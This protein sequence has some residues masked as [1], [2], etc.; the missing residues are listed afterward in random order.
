ML[1]ERSFCPSV[2]QKSTFES[3]ILYGF[4]RCQVS[5]CVPAYSGA[6]GNVVT[7]VREAVTKR[8]S[9]DFGQQSSYSLLSVHARFSSTAEG[10]CPLA[11]VLGYST[12]RSG[13]R[14]PLQRCKRR[15][16]VPR[17]PFPGHPGVTEGGNVP[18]ATSFSANALTTTND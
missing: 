14:P 13:R 17:L 9:I 10:T 8:S 7:P 11:P 18:Q 2:P 3:R 15:H 6:G 4:C 16:R 12:S 1:A 5:W